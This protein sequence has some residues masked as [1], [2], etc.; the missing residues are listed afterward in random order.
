MN[1]GPFVLAL[2]MVVLYALGSV[3]MRA[4]AAARYKWIA[5][6]N[7]GM[8]LLSFSIIHHVSNAST[9]I[10]QIGYTIG[11]VFGALLGVWLS[12]YWDTSD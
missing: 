2:L 9:M 10:D 11:G 4:I 5:V 7:T 12:T 8:C 1:N 3:N 6:T